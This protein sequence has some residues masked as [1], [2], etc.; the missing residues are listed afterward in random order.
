MRRE[1]GYNRVMEPQLAPTA[2]VAKGVDSGDGVALQS[3]ELEA[4]LLHLP[5]G[6]VV[7]DAATRRI[8]RIN[9]EAARLLQLSGDADEE[10]GFRG[11]DSFGREYGPHEWPVARTL[12]SGTSVRGEMIRFVFP[13]GTER[14]ISVTSAPVKTDDRMTAAV[15]VLDD[16]SDQE[17]RARAERDFIT[18]AAHELQT[19]I[20]SIASAVDV[21]QAGAKN[22]VADRD[23]FL[24][25]IEE[26]ADRLGRL[27]R[28]LLV[29]A[30]AQTG[31]ETPRTE[32]LHLE[33]LLRELADHRAGVVT[34]T[35]GPRLAVVANRD[36]L[37]QALSNLIDNALSHAGTAVTV[38]CSRRGRRIAIRIA[39][40]GP[41]INP[42]IRDHVFDRFFRAGSSPGFGL[43]L[44][45][46][47][48]AVE[49]IGGTLKLEP[50][51]VGTELSVLLDGATVRNP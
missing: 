7:V 26:A 8:V 25:H 28:A 11:F 2:A 46:A 44:A 49:A 31:A 47:S 24:R 14:M 3:G 23:R 30:R 50:T 33:P 10:P 38:A 42:E 41:G 22:T 35:C 12:D 6:L 45:I 43:G 15:V 48:E 21:L 16:V 5:V 34:V 20:A 32:V 13:D 51:E 4:F 19:P 40:T 18:N 39:D 1:I 17:A 27:T 9:P 36:L 29:L 37:E